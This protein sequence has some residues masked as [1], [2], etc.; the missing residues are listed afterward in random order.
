MSAG[1]PFFSVVVP[2]RGESSK[3][4][5][6]LHAL[7]CQTFPRD[8][9]EILISFDGV[10]PTADLAQE[11][12]RSEAT[13]VTSSVRQGPGA[14]RNRGA[15]EAR[16]SFLAFTE[17]DCI[18]SADWLERAAESLA[19][20]PGVD[21]LE[22]TTTR[23]NGG[24]TRRPGRHPHF[25][26]TNLFVRAEVFD[27]VGGYCEEFFDAKTGTYFREDSDLGFSLE[28]AG[29]KIAR[30]PRAR[31][32]H[33][34]E[35]PGYLDPL[36]WARR[37]EM[38]GLLSARHPRLSRERIEVHRFGPLVIRRPFVRA[39]FVFVLTLVAS[40]VALLFREP[41]LSAL[42]ALMAALFFLPIW[43]KWRFNPLRLPVLVLVPFVLVL[44]SIRG[45]ARTS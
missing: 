24:P 37:Y 12:A 18:P 23:P 30:E 19:R 2:T 15:R 41:G 7:S 6:L 36:R 4:L 10:A 5:P 17:D 26:P 25:L 11:A 38:D 31:V 40:G 45:R 20:D 22:G 34:L 33:P 3:L 21:V 44:Y 42:L 27:R 39:C 35:H 8:R 1:P 16:G 32:T 9:F 14:A 43:A 28:E 29:V 13:V